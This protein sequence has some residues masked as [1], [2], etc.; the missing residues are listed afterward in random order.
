MTNK[1]FKSN[2]RDGTIMNNNNWSA[3]GMRGFLLK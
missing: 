1:M 3:K 2:N